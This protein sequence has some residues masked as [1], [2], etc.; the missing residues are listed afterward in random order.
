MVTCFS[1]VHTK[2]LVFSLHL[3]EGNLL[4][5]ILHSTTSTGTILLHNLLHFTLN[6]NSAIV[7][8]GTAEVLEDVNGEGNDSA[9]DAIG[10]GPIPVRTHGGIRE[11]H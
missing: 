3:A 6:D 2:A 8:N 10:D 1:S 5:K 9:D 11:K 7:Q 4:G